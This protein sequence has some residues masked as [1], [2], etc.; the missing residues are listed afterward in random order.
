M[1]KTVKVWHVCWHLKINPCTYLQTVACRHIRRH[2]WDPCRWRSSGMV[3]TDTRCTPPRNTSHGS[4][5]GKYKNTHALCD[6]L[7]HCWCNVKMLQPLFFF[8]EGFAERELSYSLITASHLRVN[9]AQAILTVRAHF[10]L[11]VFLEDSQINLSTN[12]CTLFNSMCF[13][14]IHL[15]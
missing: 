2:W 10:S 9:A 3:Q 1:L 7:L 14:S 13:L 8:R 4:L 15:I 6:T 12:L 5:N 11:I